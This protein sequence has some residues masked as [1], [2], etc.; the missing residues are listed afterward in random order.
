MVKVLKDFGLTCVSSL[1][2]QKKC[3]LIKELTFSTDAP[4]HFGEHL[5]YRFGMNKHLIEI[6]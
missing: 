6:K 5:F 4:L 2:S 3:L 1:P